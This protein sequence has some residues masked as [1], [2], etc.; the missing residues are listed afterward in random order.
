MDTLDSPMNKRTYTNL[1]HPLLIIVRG[2]PG[3]GKSYLAARLH[4][5]FGE[6]AVV[7]LDPDTIDLNSQE[8]RDHSAALTA[9]GVDA[10][11]HPYRFSLGK[12]LQGITDHKIIIWNQPFTNLEMF[13]RMIARLEERAAQEHTTLPMLVVEVSVDPAIAKA[14]VTKRMAE[15]GNT[16][17]DEVFA[18]R[19][20][21][22]SSFA[23]EGYNIAAVRGDG[24]VAA[25]A[26]SIVDRANKLL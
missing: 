21:E 22:Y 14:R 8:Y 1:Q 24:D 3:S 11:V 16:I 23:S 6:D 10:M 25:A 2:L 15:G 12:A 9:E 18:Q 13:K 17:S 7:A 19:L 4:K 20:S 26:R 5:A